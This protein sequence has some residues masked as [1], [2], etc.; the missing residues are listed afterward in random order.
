[1]QLVC[2]ILMVDP[3]V[4]TRALTI[5]LMHT[6][7][8][9]IEQYRDA[10][11]VSRAVNNILVLSKAEAHS[12]VLLIVPDTLNPIHHS[13]PTHPRAPSTSPTWANIATCVDVVWKLPRRNRQGVVWASVWVACAADRPLPGPTLL[14]VITPHSDWHPRYLW[15]RTLQAQQLRTAL[16]QPRKRAA[17]IL[18]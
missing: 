3:G 12:K 14:S 11:K 13:T 1:M 9:V 6:R 8:E 5:N 10:Q 2:R 7:G 4:L 16:H 17:A 15:L 18:F